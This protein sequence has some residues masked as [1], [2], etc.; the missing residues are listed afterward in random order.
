MKIGGL[1]NHK[2]NKKKYMESNKINTNINMFMLLDKL[3]Y[4]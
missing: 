1:K 4:K 3:F 2:F